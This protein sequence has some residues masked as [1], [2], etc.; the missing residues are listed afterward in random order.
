MTKCDP[1]ASNLKG[2]LEHIRNLFGSVAF[3]S[4]IL[5]IIHHSNHPFSDQEVYNALQSMTEI[6]T[7][8]AEG[9]KKSFSKDIYERWD[10][11]EPKPNQL[12][13]LMKKI[14]KLEPYTH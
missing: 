5:L 13:N 10:N 1:R 11:I 7:I 12:Q 14:N 4:L 2:D 8:I 6:K 9:T 3:K